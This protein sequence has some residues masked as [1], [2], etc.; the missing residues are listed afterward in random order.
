MALALVT[1]KSWCVQVSSSAKWRELPARAAPVAEFSVPARVVEVQVRV[2]DDG[3]VFGRAARVRA[4]RLR[5]RAP[6]PYAVHLDL[7]RRPLVAEARLDED[8]LA[9]ALDEE[10]V[11]VE[12]YAVQRVG[13]RY[14]LPERAG[15]DAEHRAPVEAELCVGHDLNAV[16]AELHRNH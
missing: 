3:Q 4:Q 10:A 5:E 2:D 16:V 11:G 8:A 15:H 13:R 7:A 1:Q 12:A 14:S 6:A 9:R